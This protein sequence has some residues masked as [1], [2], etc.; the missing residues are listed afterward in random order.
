MEAGKQ[1]WFVLRENWAEE[2]WP[3]PQQDVSNT[4]GNEFAPKN[5]H[6]TETNANQQSTISVITNQNTSIS[7]SIKVGMEAPPT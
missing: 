2:L 1:A 7:V 5:K 3:N 4:V 6:P